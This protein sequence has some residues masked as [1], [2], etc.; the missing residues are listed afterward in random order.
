MKGLFMCRAVVAV[1]MAG[2]A[3]AL[4]AKTLTEADIAAMQGHLADLAVRIADAKEDAVV[5][6]GSA[7]GVLAEMRAQ[8]LA[9]TA[10]I[11]EARLAAGEAGALVEIV[12]PAVA[13]NLEMAAAI[14]TD[15]V[16]QEQVV[17]DAEAEANMTGGL[18]KAVAL[19]RVQAEKL[20]LARLRGALVQARFGAT[21][22]V[23]IEDVALLAPGASAPYA[24][25]TA[26]NTDQYVL[27][28]AIR[29]A[30]AWADPDHS[31][32]DYRHQ[33]FEAL[34]L[35][36]YRF[37]GWWGIR[38]TRAEIDDS[39]V[40]NAI[41]LQN[42]VERS[43]SIGDPPRLVAGCR[44]GEVIFVYNSG[45]FLGSRYN[46][47]GIDVMLRVDQ[48]PAED[49]RWSKLVSNEGAGLFGAK[50]VSMLRRLYDADRLF[51]RVE[52][53]RGERIDASFDLAGIARVAD[54]AAAACGVSLLELSREDYR[55]IQQMLNAGGFDAG[56]P[57]GVWGAGSKAALRAFQ[58]AKGLPAT[59]APDRATLSAMGLDF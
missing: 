13:P 28:T 41:H 31:E 11:L 45:K 27:E 48:L 38:E 17:A 19:A 5:H 9:L 20:T 59:G 52:G 12:L 6:T 10:A 24:S 50:A 7:I 16:A 1:L 18:I 44:E 39:P 33:I 55:T 15:I 40:I 2:A 22:P 37:S 35:D 14:E 4:S 36:G 25:R 43:R 57:D 3:G 21:L 46:E 53:Y 54:A 32:I 49:A 42:D 47:N 51:I 8:T 30:P 56:R 58:E 26:S 34:A 29:E 23:E